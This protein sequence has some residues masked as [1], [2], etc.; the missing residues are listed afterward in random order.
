MID[1]KDQVAVDFE[2]KQDSNGKTRNN[3]KSQ[4]NS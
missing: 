3:D 1:A 2:N 4:C